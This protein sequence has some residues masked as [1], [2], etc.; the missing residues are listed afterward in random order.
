MDDLN[1]D[2]GG[3]DDPEILAIV[4]R[5]RQRLGTCDTVAP[6]AFRGKEATA[7]GK[8]SS[9]SRDIDE[10]S[11]KSPL[12]FDAMEQDDDVPVPRRTRHGSG[13]SKLSQDSRSYMHTSSTP[14]AV[15][16]GY[17]NA[18]SHLWFQTRPCG[19][20]P[21]RSGGAANDFFARSNSETSDPA[22]C[23]D[24]S[25]NSNG[26]IVFHIREDLSPTSGARGRQESGITTHVDRTMTSAAKP[27]Q[28]EAS[29]PAGKVRSYIRSRGG[30]TAGGMQQVLSG[31][32][33]LVTST[34]VDHGN[35]S[36]LFPADL[37]PQD[38]LDKRKRD[39]AFAENAAGVPPD[40]VERNIAALRRHLQMEREQY[41]AALKAWEVE[42]AG[43]LEEIYTKN[44]I[45]H[46]LEEELMERP[47]H[48]DV[49]V[50][51]RIILL[52]LSAARILV[53]LVQGGP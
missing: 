2:D 37:A 21:H 32:G 52:I 41:L 51:R 14:T 20:G 28:D 10:V 34:G 19:G 11:S 39:A 33:V 13:G 25:T 44:K 26:G 18:S 6:Q 48:R 8:S 40:E 29:L 36:V 50:M 5:Q 43:Y 35:P 12:P 47:S 38:P 42:R 31:G 24:A 22:L 23:S 9:S 4:E 16:T 46:Q 27:H 30:S 1:G 49:A 3:Y 7:F 15:E 45:V 53:V 17:L